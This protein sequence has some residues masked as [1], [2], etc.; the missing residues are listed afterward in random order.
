M[1]ESIAIWL[2]SGSSQFRHSLLSCLDSNPKI[3]LL[4][5]S[6]ADIEPLAAQINASRP[7]VLLV[8]WPARARRARDA[9]T[10]SQLAALAP[11][12]VV[13]VA[14]PTMGIV[15]G[16]LTNHLHG[17]L[18]FDSTPEECRRAITRVREGEVWIPRSL[19]AASLAE[20]LLDRDA[21]QDA[22]IPRS[23]TSSGLFTTRE[24]EI[25]RLVR[26][27]MTNKQ[28]GHELGIVED[29]VKKHLQHIYDKIG[30]RRRSVLV[31]GSGPRRA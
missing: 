6:N 22:E 24:R 11:R 12:I 5:Q 30:V 10:P 14:A 7:D 2:A 4:G 28:I 3:V 25:V 18:Q 27:G 29:T 17:C 23:K 9:P 15:A 1:V 19:L 8:D 20:L 31:I 16:V 13:L 21:R 26:Q